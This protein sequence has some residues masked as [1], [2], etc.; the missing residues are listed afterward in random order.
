MKT[1]IIVLSV[2]LAVSTVASAQEATKSSQKEA[3]KTTYTCPMH[4]EEV[5]STEAKCSKCG[6]TMVKTKRLK[7][8]T[9][10]KGKKTSIEV[11]TKYVCPKDGQTSDKP[12]K[13]PKCGMDMTKK[14][15]QKATYTCPM[16]PGEVSLENGKC[17]KC[18]M[19]M[20][21]TTEKK[22]IHAVKGS[23]SGSEV[24]TKY[25]C[26]MDGQTSDKPGKC[27]KCGMD[28]TKE[29]VQKATYT[30]PM[31]PDEVGLENGKCAK[32]GMEMV[33]TIEKKYIHAVKGSQ[34]GSEVVTKYVCKADNQTSDKAGKCPKCGMEMTKME[35]KKK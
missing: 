33:K 4:P 30:C 29:E 34:A 8:D 15:V 32:C 20:V 22:Y 35:G 16:H 19:E 2:F 1:L 25:V 28:M 23:Q 10:G 3:Q 24:V 31:H 17:A 12:G 7:H 9:S 14:E 18:G 27:P 26:K 6:M 11:V 13:C 21:K 5:S